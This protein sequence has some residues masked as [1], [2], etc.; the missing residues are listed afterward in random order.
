MTQIIK[1]Y[2]KDSLRFVPSVAL[3]VTVWYTKVEKDAQHIVNDAQKT[4]LTF[5]K[6]ENTYFSY[7]NIFKYFLLIN[8]NQKANKYFSFNTVQVKAKLQ[9]LLNDRKLP[10]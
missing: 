2:T 6:L 4:T 7:N 10:N 1:M 9:N 8:Y 5:L 3:A